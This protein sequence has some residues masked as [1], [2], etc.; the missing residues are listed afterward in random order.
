MSKEEK[1]KIKLEIE[2]LKNEKNR[3]EFIISQ[4]NA[5]C[6]GILAIAIA[7]FIPLS[8][9]YVYWYISFI[10]FIFLVVILIL[11]LMIIPGRESKEIKCIY[12]KLNEKYEQLL[13]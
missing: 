10:G 3:L 6:L 8:I 2:K 7:V 5:L 1:E 11:V 12:C 4:R 13:K 9:N